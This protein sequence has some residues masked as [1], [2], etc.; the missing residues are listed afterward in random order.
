[1]A[2]SIIR[3]IDTNAF[4][5]V[6]AASY[7]AFRAGNINSS[8]PVI[9]MGYNCPKNATGNYYLQTNDKPPYSRGVSGKTY[10]KTIDSYSYSIIQAFTSCQLF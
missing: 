2:E 9:Q 5:S 1:M 10:N 6:S 3:S 4:L 8:A 7:N